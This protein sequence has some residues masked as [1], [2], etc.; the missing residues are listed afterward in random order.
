[1][2]EKT[3]QAMSRFLLA[4]ALLAALPVTLEVVAHE[5]KQESEQASE[6]ESEQPENFEQ[7]AMEA[8][9]QATMS[10]GESHQW[11]A[12]LAGDWTFETSMWM[13]PNAPP[14]KSSGEA[15]KSMIMEG[16]FLQEEMSGE[17]M[18]R[19]FTGRGLTGFDNV[20]KE[21]V[22][23]WIDNMSTGL[24]TVRGEIDTENHRMEVRGEM[25]EP[26]SG[27]PVQLK[28]VTSVVDEDHHTFE[29]FV[30]LPNGDEMKQMEIH[31]TRK[32][33]S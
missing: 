27:E 19:P 16:R 29:Y 2:S 23:S 11:L 18:G 28:L 32:G 30:V 7:A 25:T 26:A 33:D 15:K 31:Y 5:P 14:T 9:W 3:R 21:V 10:P 8:D 4:V 6:Q 20:T 17:M 24:A 12:K 22:G 1:M 13:N